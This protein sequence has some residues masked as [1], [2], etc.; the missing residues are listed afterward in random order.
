MTEQQRQAMSNQVE[1]YR[2]HGLQVPI[3]LYDR[4][5]ATPDEPNQYNPYC[6]GWVQSL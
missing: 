2:A 1:I 4:I 3:W 5:L 6:N